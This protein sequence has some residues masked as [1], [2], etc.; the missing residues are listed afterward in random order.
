MG[1]ARLARNTHCATMPDL[2]IPER[3]QPFDTLLKSH[4]ALGG[5]APSEENLVSFISSVRAVLSDI[6]SVRASVTRRS[7]PPKCGGALAWTRALAWSGSLKSWGVAAGGGGS[8]A[9]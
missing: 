5:E 7:E 3:L 6:S 2:P 9:M 1:T 4:E 8:G